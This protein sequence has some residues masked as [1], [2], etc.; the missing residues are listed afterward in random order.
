MFPRLRI[1]NEQEWRDWPF[2][3]D[4]LASFFDFY[5]KDFKN[6]WQSTPPVRVSLLGISKPDKINRPFPTYPPP[7]MSLRTYYLDALT[8]AASTILPAVDG[9]VSYPATDMK[10]EVTFDITFTEYTEFSGYAKLCLW[11][12]C[13]DHDDMDIFVILCK[14]DEN[15]T[16]LRH[17]NY[18]PD[19]VRREN[20]PLNNVVQYQG[21]TGVIRASHRKWL[22]THP[23]YLAPIPQDSDDTVDDPPPVWDGKKELWHPHKKSEK[24]PNGDIVKVEFTTW[25]MGMTF[26]KGEKMRVRISGRDMC[27]V[28][29]AERMFPVPQ[30]CH[31]EHVS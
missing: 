4:D 6:D 26:E 9:S 5:L 2:W 30:V 16:V 18:P 25:P 15:G 17:V 29:T 28:E 20:L 27:L 10:S 23:S 3:Q 21:P 13:N 12:Q 7:S 19:K 14:I 22:A 11:M 24:I 8:K 1:H 31:R